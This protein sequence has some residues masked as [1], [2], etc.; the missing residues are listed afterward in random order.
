MCSTEVPREPFDLLVGSTQTKTCLM[1]GSVCAVTLC[2]ALT[3]SKRI[4]NVLKAQNDSD[5]SSTLL[6]S[7]LI[8]TVGLYSDWSNTAT[9]NS[10]ESYPHEGFCD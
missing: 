5:N 2:T 9:N 8:W 1:A 4:K 3:N 6:A 7:K 10:E